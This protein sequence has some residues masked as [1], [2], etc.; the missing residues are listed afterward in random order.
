[1]SHKICIAKILIAK[2]LHLQISL[3]VQLAF[4]QLH[5]P[6]QPLL[7]LQL[8]FISS[9]QAWLAA[10]RVVQT[11]IQEVVHSSQLQPHDAGLR[12]SPQ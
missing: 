12:V 3:Q 10:S 11:D 5:L 9:M 1:M 2:I 7:L 6:P 8:H 4:L